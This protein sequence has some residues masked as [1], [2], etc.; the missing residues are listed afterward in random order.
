MENFS[1]KY[2]SKLT[3][4]IIFLIPGVLLSIAIIK[5]LFI[6]GIISI[7][8]LFALI[9]S[10]PFTKG[11]ENLWM[12]VLSLIT[13]TPLNIKIA[14]TAYT[15]LCNL[16]DFKALAVFIAITLFFIA[17]DAEQIVLGLITRIVKPKQKEIDI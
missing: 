17:S 13:L 10:T 2:L 7:A 5:H 11:V 16:F 15:V 4:I 3:M 1:V 6:V 14:I 8:L 12:Y 9:F